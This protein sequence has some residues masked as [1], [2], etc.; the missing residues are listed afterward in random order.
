M[1]FGVI[2]G[3]RM[4]MGLFDKKFFDICGEKISF[5]DNRKLEDG[6]MCSQ[7]AKLISPL[8]TDRRKRSVAEMK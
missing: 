1:F 5:P 3:S 6:N 4:T 7:C 8:L 2:N